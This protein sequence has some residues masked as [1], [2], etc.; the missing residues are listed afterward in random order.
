MKVNLW[1]RRLKGASG[2]K[3]YGEHNIKILFIG[4][5]AKLVPLLKKPSSFYQQEGLF[6]L[7]KWWAV[8]DLNL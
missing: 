6:S 7:K 3:N 8:E 5:S 4:I 2:I 1:T